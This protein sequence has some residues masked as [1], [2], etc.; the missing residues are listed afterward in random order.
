M[1]SPTATL[2]VVTVPASA[3][4][5]PSSWT[6]AEPRIARADLIALPT[7]TSNTLAH[8]RTNFLYHPPL[9]L[10][11]RLPSYRTTA[12]DYRAATCVRH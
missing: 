7:T 12:R 2:T 10:A 6:R 1:T 3:A 11:R 9:V 8:L 4:G 5:S